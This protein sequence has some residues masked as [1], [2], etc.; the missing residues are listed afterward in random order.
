MTFDELRE[1]SIGRTAAERLGNRPTLFL[2]RD[3]GAL[4]RIAGVAQSGVVA[5]RLAK[6]LVGRR[7]MTGVVVLLPLKPGTRQRVRDLLAQGPPF[8]LVAA[9]LTRHQVFLADRE[10]VFVVEL[11]SESAIEHLA[12]NTDFWVTA[13]AWREC[14]AGPARLARLAFSWVRPGDASGDVSFA[15]TPGPGDSDGGDVFSPK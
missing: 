7:G 6:P 10:A 1:I 3:S 15:A 13:A 5:E 2:E 11:P 8:D 14:V 9:G 12:K 4:I